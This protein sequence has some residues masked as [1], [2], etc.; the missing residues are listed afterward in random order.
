MFREMTSL[1][2]FILTNAGSYLQLESSS[3]LAYT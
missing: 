1:S 2:S 3:A